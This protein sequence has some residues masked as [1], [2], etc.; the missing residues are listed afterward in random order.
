[1]RFHMPFKNTRVIPEEVDPFLLRLK[2][3]PE[4]PVI[5]YGY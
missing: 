5:T 4:D 2:Q 1:M 3:V